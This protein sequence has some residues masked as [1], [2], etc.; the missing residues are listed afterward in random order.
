I[1]MESYAMADYMAA[2]GMAREQ[3]RVVGST[4]DDVL[5]EVSAHREFRRD[6]LCRSLGLPAHR[7]IILTALPPDFLY[8]TGG[9]PEC[10][11][12]NFESLVEFWVKSLCSVNGYSVVISMHPSAKPEDARALER[13]GARISTLSTPELVPLCDFFVASISSTIRWAIACEK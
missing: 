4:A 1:T 12:R 9:R 6:E 5:A 13:H 11:F 2:A 10:D 3:M 7:P 8:L